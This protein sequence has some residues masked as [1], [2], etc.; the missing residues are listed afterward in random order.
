MSNL[1]LL[2]GERGK[3]E[4]AD[5]KKLIMG[6]QE[7]LA[8]AETGELK[9]LCYASIDSDGQNVTLGVL[10]GENTG[11]HEMI[12]LSHMLSDALLE[13]ARD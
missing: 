5:Q 11:L 1:V 4:K 10:R 8:R 12:G 13:S 3:R 7:L 6:L 9:A 2:S